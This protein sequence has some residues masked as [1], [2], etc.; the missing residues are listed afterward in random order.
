MPCM[1]VGREVH[2]GVRQ[3]VRRLTLAPHEYDIH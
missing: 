1:P 3:S 2:E